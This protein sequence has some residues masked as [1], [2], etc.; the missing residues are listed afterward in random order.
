[1]R[2]PSGRNYSGC[3]P[4]VNAVPGFARVASFADRDA[5]GKPVSD[6]GSHAR[7]EAS[8]RP[9]K[10]HAAS[11][12]VKVQHGQREMKGIY[13][14]SLD[15]YTRP[16]TAE[17]PRAVAAGGRHRRCRPQ[18]P[19]QKLSGRIQKNARDIYTAARG[20]VSLPIRPETT[21]RR[22]ASVRHSE[23]RQRPSNRR[24]SE[25]CPIRKSSRCP[26]RRKPARKC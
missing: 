8:S 22:W 17:Q 13:T 10:E 1:M 6:A 26:L 23:K 5:R 25:L 3:D 14:Q 19:C 7:H 24:R 2:L 11:P 20:R 4:F 12:P 15:R 16:A 9:L 21:P 18:A